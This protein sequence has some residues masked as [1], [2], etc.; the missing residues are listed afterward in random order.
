MP[1]GVAVTSGTSPVDG[2]E[3]MKD[4][5]KFGDR[6]SFAKVICVIC[7]LAKS[8]GKNWS[9]KIMEEIK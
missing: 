2:E 4:Y 5:W 8:K 6:T 7:S 3:D 1:L 9:I